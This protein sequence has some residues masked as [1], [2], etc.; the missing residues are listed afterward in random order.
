[1]VFITKLGPNGTSNCWYPPSF[2]KEELSINFWGKIKVCEFTTLHFIMIDTKLMV[3]SNHFIP[4]DERNLG[5]MGKVHIHCSL[6]LYLPHF[7]PY[8]NFEQMFSLFLKC[9]THL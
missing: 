7:V 3:V 4:M 9:V 5:L 2:L 6:H 8:H 1:M